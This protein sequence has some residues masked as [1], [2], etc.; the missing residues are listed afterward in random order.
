[1]SI[2][3]SKARD[4][5]LGLT[6]KLTFGKLKDCRLC[7]V[8][9]DHYEY[10][11]WANKQGYVQFQKEVTDLIEEQAHF[12]RWEGVDEGNSQDDIRDVYE[13]ITRIDYDW[14]DD[15]PF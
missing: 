10:L 6:D 13:K 4:P 11:I 5:K 12:K 1:M 7:D 15:V 8:I 3:F 14:E 2:P 9:Q